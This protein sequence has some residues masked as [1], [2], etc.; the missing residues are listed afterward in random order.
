[1]TVLDGFN[2]WTKLSK[3][4]EGRTADLFCDNLDAVFPPTADCNCRIS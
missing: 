4:A 1:M 2:D 3:E